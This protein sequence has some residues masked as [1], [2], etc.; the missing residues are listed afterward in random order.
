M[1]INKNKN[2]VSHLYKNQHYFECDD[3][4]SYFMRNIKLR[5]ERKRS[6][7]ILKDFRRFI[8]S[9]NL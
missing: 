9:E 4:T 1:I 8:P 6:I 2:I 7:I 5:K 3:R